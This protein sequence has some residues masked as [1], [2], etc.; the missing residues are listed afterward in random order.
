MPSIWMADDET[1]P[2]A[3]PLWSSLQLESDIITALIDGGADINAP[4]GYMQDKRRPLRVAIAAGNEAAVDLLLERGEEIGEEIDG[5]MVLMLPV[6][7]TEHAFV[8][9]S[10]D[11]EQKLLAIY[12][13]LRIFANETDDDGRNVLHHA[14]YRGVSSPRTSWTAMWIW[15]WPTGRTSGGRILTNTPLSLRRPPTS[16]PVWPSPCVAASQLR[17]STGQEGISLLPSKALP[18]GSRIPPH[19]QQG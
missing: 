2:V 4:E 9:P 1:C 3:L 11:Y 12:E 6:M 5:A 18:R 10:R 15:W 14:G 19:P 8:R 7:V 17:T 16:P 13:R